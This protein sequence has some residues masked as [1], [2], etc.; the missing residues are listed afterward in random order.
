M[1]SVEIFT[2]HAK[3]YRASE[4]LYSVH[5][6]SMHWADLRQHE[7]SS[8]VFPGKKK[9]DFCHTDFN[10]FCILTPHN[11]KIHVSSNL[12][13]WNMALVIGDMITVKIARF[14]L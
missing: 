3:C 14:A 11:P 10:I 7:L 2:Q 5:V 6:P 4:V 13:A 9:S 8:V 1:L 12:I